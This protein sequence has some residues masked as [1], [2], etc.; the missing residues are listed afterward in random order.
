MNASALDRGALWLVWRSLSLPASILLAIVEPVVSFVLGSLALLG[1]LEHG[2]RNIPALETGSV[3]PILHIQGHDRCTDTQSRETQAKGQ[4]PAQIK[5][6]HG[7]SSVAWWRRTYAD[8]RKQNVGNV[9]VRKHAV[10]HCK[11]CIRQSE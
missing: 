3:N 7:D 6:K 2:R 1:V 4:A 5:P 9:F 8:D 11:P 10:L